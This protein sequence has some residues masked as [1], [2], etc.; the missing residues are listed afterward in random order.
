M[1]LQFML[2]LQDKKKKKNSNS[3]ELLE[4]DKLIFE[5]AEPICVIE[6]QDGSLKGLF[7]IFCNFLLKLYNVI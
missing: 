7:T 4:E 5:L 2:Q 1:G 3:A 6:F